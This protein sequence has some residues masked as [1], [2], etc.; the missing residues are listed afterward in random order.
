[1]P[2]YAWMCPYK[3]DCGYASDPKCVKI[4]NLAKFWIWQASL[5]VNVTLRPSRHLPAYR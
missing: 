5:Y 2:K 4:L 1:M 3:Q